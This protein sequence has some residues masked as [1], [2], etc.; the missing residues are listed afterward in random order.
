VHPLRDLPAEFFSPP[1]RTRTPAL[2]VTCW[3]STQ[4]RRTFNRHGEFPHVTPT[5]HPV[6]VKARRVL[7]FDA[8]ARKAI[9]LNGFERQWPACT[10]RDV[11]VLLWTA[12]SP[13]F[14]VTR[15]VNSF[16]RH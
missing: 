13:S 6:D 2:D 12:N 9:V 3:I 14:S 7:D 5:E 10:S 8:E 16:Q 11:G 4:L 1:T 15:L